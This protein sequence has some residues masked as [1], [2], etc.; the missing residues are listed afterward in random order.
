MSVDNAMSPASSVL[1]WMAKN[2]SNAYIACGPETDLLNTRLP[3]LHLN[4]PARS[5]RKESWHAW[6]APWTRR[7]GKDWKTGAP[8]TSKF[9]SNDWALYDQMVYLTKPI[10]P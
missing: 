5:P 10:D 8:D 1:E 3:T 4:E 2:S 9:S 6:Q 7:S